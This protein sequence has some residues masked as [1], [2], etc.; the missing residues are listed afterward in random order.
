MLALRFHSLSWHQP[1]GVHEL[2]LLWQGRGVLLEER[3]MLCTVEVLDR[4]AAGHGRL[5][6]AKLPLQKGIEPG[7]CSDQMEAGIT[8]WLN[9]TH[10]GAVPSNTTATL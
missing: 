3:R 1:V 10:V 6:V 5:R 2:V 9:T 4:K 8:D 7:A